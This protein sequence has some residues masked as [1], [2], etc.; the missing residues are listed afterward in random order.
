MGISLR[1]SFFRSFDDKGNPF[2]RN[3]IQSEGAGLFVLAE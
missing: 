2:E 3:N 1:V